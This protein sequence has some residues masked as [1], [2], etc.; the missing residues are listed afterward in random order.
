M[1]KR[2][3]LS[4]VLDIKPNV[5]NWKF[6]VIVFV[7]IL[8]V[9]LFGAKKYIGAQSLQEQI[10]D[11][12][13]QNSQT[14]AR[15]DALKVEASSYQETINALAAQINAYQRE[16]NQRQAES[17]QLKVQIAEKEIELTKQ[18]GVLGDNIKSMYLEG[19]ISTVE[20]LATSKDLSNYLDK[21]QYREVT[22]NSMKATLDKVTALKAELQ[23]KND[24]VQRI[25]KEQEQLKV[26]ADTQ[27]AEQDRLLGFN[28]S[29]QSEFNNQI[30]NNQS[31]IADLKRQQAIENA[32]LF[33]GGGGML[34][35][36]GYPWGR[37]P[38]FHNGQVEGSCP[39][40]DW[41]VNGSIWN[42]NLSGYGYRNCTDWVA[43]R[44]EVAGGHVPGGLGHAKL[45]DDR[46]PSYGL[47]VSSVARVGAAAVSNN[48]YYGHVMYVEAV[49]SD[50][51]IV[52]SDYNRAGTGKYDTN[53]LSASTAAN[54]RYVY[55]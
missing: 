22:S 5:I 40:Y 55:F 45:W 21:Q 19:D 31:K 23:T 18:K 20:M 30:K 37:A 51:T 11:L 42:W 28:Q 9:G 36:G 32:R 1:A 52:V 2:T 33:G 46:A 3:R 44:V 25:I 6:G 24:E 12:S 43:Y 38:C 27:K 26:A 39:N 53:T 29:Q 4:K 7:A 35:G 54:L 15:V 34:G 8:S 47:T 41:S 50:G 13:D 17:E 16:I 14:Q 49:N 48:G 10:N